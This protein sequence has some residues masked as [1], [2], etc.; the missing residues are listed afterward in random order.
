MKPLSVSDK[1]ILAAVDWQ[2]AL[3]LIFEAVKAYMAKDW[4]KLFSVVIQLIRTVV[5]VEER[6]GVKLDWSTLLPIIM[7]IV[8]MII[9]MIGSGED[10]GDDDGGIKLSA[11]SQSPYE[12][13]EEVLRTIR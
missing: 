10:D 13:F 8:K 2:E 7:Q 4:E 12:M 5:S 6:M 9:E 11:P 3:Q 1:K